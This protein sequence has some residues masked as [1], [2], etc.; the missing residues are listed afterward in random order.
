MAKAIS[1]HSAPK[2][3]MAMTI[4]AIGVVP[5]MRTYNTHIDND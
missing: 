1:G 5:P 2:S 3:G 4:A